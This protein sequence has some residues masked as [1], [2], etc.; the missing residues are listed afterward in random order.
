[1][2]TV[3]DT[4]TD[5]KKEEVEEAKLEAKREKT[6]YGGLIESDEDES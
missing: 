4:L 5:E 6:K 3:E 2:T 1:M